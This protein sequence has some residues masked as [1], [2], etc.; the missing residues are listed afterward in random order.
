M[1]CSRGWLTAVASVALFAGSASA[2]GGL[3]G[4]STMSCTLPYVAAPTVRGES[5]VEQVGD[6]VMNCTG[7]IP[8][9]Y[10]AQIPQANIS[11]YLNTQITSRVSPGSSNNVSDALLIIDEP[12]SASLSSYGA[13]LPQIPC[14]T[15]TTGCVAY[16]S[17]TG[18]NVGV[19]SSNPPP[20][21]F[22]AAPN[23]YRG[24]V[25]GNAITFYGVPILPP[26]T[27]G[28]RIYRI[29]NIRAN[30]NG[31]SN[32]G[33]TPG[34][35]SGSVGI[36]P[37]NAFTINQPLNMLAFVQSGLN[38]SLRS[39]TN[40]C[41]SGSGGVGGPSA[42]LRY[43][44]NFPTAFKTRTALVN[45]NTNAASGFTGQNIPGQ[46]YGTSESGFTVPS[47]AIGNTIAGLADSG[48]RLKAVFTN[49][50]NGVSIYVST[51]NVANL[52]TAAPTGTG[53]PAAV[54]LTGETVPYGGSALVAATTSQG[55]VGY[56]QV[57][58]VN[59]TGIAVWEVTGN[60]N[61][62][63]TVQ[64]MDFGVYGSSAAAASAS[65]FMSYAPNPTNG[66]FNGFG[67]TDPTQVNIIPRFADTSTATPFGTIASCPASTTVG[68]TGPSSSD[69][70]Q[71]VVFT[72]S[73]QT[74]GSPGVPVTTGTITITDTTNN[75][76]LLGPTVP[77]SNGRVSVT[78][79]NLAVGVQNIQALYTPGPGFTG[80]SAST[81]ITV[82]SQLAMTCATTTTATPN[83][84]AEGFT[85]LVGDILFVCN[86]GRALTVG[87][88]IPQATITVLLNTQVTSRLLNG[89]GSEALLLI[90]E[91]GSTSISGYG[92]TLPQIPCQTPLIGCAEYVGNVP[93]QN[94]S[95]AANGVPV[96]AAGGTTPAP[97]VFRGVV[98]GNS[99]TFYG[100]P[101][102]PPGNTG[103]RIYR[104]T[105]IRGN[106]TAF[107]TGG[108]LPPTIT[109][110]LSISPFTSFTIQQ[111]SNTLAFVQTGLTSSLRN[112]AGNGPGGPANFSQC[113]S[114]AVGS[115]GAAGILRY[116]ENF[117][118][119]FKTTTAAIN[120]T[121][122]TFFGITSQNIPGQVY[123]AESGF[124]V[125]V[126]G[127]SI[128][129]LADWGTRLKAVFRNVPS[130][131]SIYVS[132]GNIAG[133]T[134]APTASGS[135]R[136]ALVTSETA[137]DANGLPV[138]ATGT[139]MS[140]N[141][142][143]FPVT[144]VNGTGVAVWELT[145]NNYVTNQ[146]LDFGVYFSYSANGAL[147][148]PISVSMSYAPNSTNGA[149]NAAGA[150]DPAQVNIIPRFTD[151][152]TA[153]PF[154]TIASC[155]AGV[156]T[157][158]SVTG[159]PA[160]TYGQAV[161]F[162]ASVQS[163]GSPAFPATTGTVT[164]TDTAT[165]ATLL[166]AATPNSNGQVSVTTS[167]LAA[168]SHT[169]QASYAPG[170]G[171]TGSTSA[172]WPITVGKAPLTVTANN[173][174]KVYGAALPSFTAAYSG[175][176]NG[177]T[178][179]AISGAPALTTTATAT[180]N[181]AGYPIAPAAGTLAAANYTFTFVNG[182]LS[183]TKA[184]TSALLST[185]SGTLTATVAATPPGA[186]TPTGTVQFLSG[187]A[188]VGTQALTGG[189]ASLSAPPGP[190]TAVYSGDA[191]FN[192]STS[193]TV[194][195]PRTASSL[196]LSSSPNPST[197]G[198]AV[199]FTASIGGNGGPSSGAPSGAVQFLD[200]GQVLGSGSISGGQ[201]TYT[202]SA[203]TGGYHTITAQYNGDGTFSA[204]QATYGQTVSAAITMTVTA[205]PS[206]PAFGQTVA[207]TANITVAPPPGFA[208]P[209]GTVTF[210]DGAA[211]PFAQNATLGI[212]PLASGVATFSLNTLGVG[213]HTIIA[214]YSG[215]AT[216]PSY[217]RTT[218]V[219]VSPIAT[220]TS[221][222]LSINSAGQ[223]VLTAS[224]TPVAQGSAVPTGS[225][226]FMDTSN[227]ATVANAAVS[228][229][230]AAAMAAVS[231]F[232]HA[233][234]AVYSGDANFKG[235]TSAPLPVALNAAANLSISFAP[236]E[237]ASLF[238]IAGLSADTPATLPLTTSLAGVSVK[239]TDSSGTVRLAQLYGVFAS[240]GQVNFVVPGDIAPGM[241]LV[242]VT[243]PGGGV[244]STVLMIAKA[245]VGIFT[246]NMNGQGV[247]AGQVVH[248]HADGSQTIGS[249]AALNATGPGYVAAPIDLGPPSDQVV[250]VLY[251]TGIRHAA[252]LTATLNGATLPVLFF[253]AQGQYAGLDQINIVL[254]R[255]VAG[256]GLVNI[257]ISADGQAANSVTVAIQ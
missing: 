66:A 108:T 4:G 140:G 83:I 164:I 5:F 9:V 150:T 186:G 146:N 239:I 243:L 30:A 22:A 172:A 232:G 226:Q 38:T 128:A 192:G 117:P 163:T 199:T 21:A 52:S 154:A 204:G 138:P 184:A 215:D 182:T 103:S 88:Q 26:A 2:Q 114:A 121:T 50:P 134:T 41:G 99:V 189:A 78:V 240:A 85:E 20:A 86:N 228:G 253:G 130:G 202:T 139:V 191:N 96:T 82:S 55:N 64:N 231:A 211:T 100:V 245:A 238:N 65:V 72:A 11:V 111:P 169:I 80:S 10:G 137:P 25:A 51:V 236:D 6:L 92:P 91:P 46:F 168:G 230:S 8:P 18:A 109:G 7:G 203:L 249:P 125:G 104:I 123:N 187:A 157:A 217:S 122:N 131:V 244:E 198:Q 28:A 129:G 206:A 196:S 23:V 107:P 207:L 234:E 152:S 170:P 81:S 167:N 151:T 12:G 93:A 71:E 225:V 222:S 36:S 53:N 98:S 250:L 127:G 185:S 257:R 29:T 237:V 142:S 212:A 176:V 218:T 224:V 133:L 209:T 70:G 47:V 195:N 208:A 34:T 95:P 37:A 115:S 112:T 246:A 97:N 153:T 193:N 213:A 223:A 31:I 16:V 135:P 183:I 161:T 57:P 155:Q 43:S 120:G 19:P 174:N 94:G 87:S 77:D 118:T 248:V 205:S 181:V 105:N 148:G 67:A 227:S 79:S 194:V 69:S 84:R 147:P 136:A 14:P 141:V 143:Y 197:L 251:G 1:A 56:A 110:S 190:V 162:T 165:G 242:T 76:S 48:T 27:S 144:I 3:T 201:A 219:T 156:S 180:S 73:V 74:A 179:A 247:F 63:T 42:V 58:I 32:G 35:I 256:A 44:E 145:A 116:T 113:S 24:V 158:A 159:P 15:P 68:I 45:G 229:G 90:D 173:A 132:T 220:A 216:W 160:S 62:F 177:D 39:S 210:Q 221:V 61:G 102:L 101:I 166:A 124:T 60:S 241:A 119:A 89:G 235:S 178:P 200:G 40:Q 54:L 17:N 171:F 149:F 106:A 188:V 252:S 214:A 13:G 33:P 126:G 233:I 75:A 59:G 49:V 254:P 255:S 175:F